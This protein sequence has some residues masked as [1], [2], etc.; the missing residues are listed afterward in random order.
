MP[1]YLLFGRDAQIL[2]LLES[3]ARPDSVLV[4]DSTAAALRGEWPY[5]EE[6]E[7]TLGDGSSVKVR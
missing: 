4:S 7:V 3:S 1:R 5:L 6:S 2:N